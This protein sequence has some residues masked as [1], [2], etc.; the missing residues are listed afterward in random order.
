ML[1]VISST[2]ITFVSFYVREKGDQK[3]AFLVLRFQ[4]FNTTNHQ[5]KSSQNVKNH[6]VYAVLIFVSYNLTA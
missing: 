4:N 5:F 6:I 3:D 2:A 1:T